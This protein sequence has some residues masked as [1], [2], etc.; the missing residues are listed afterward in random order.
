[1][2]VE[3]STGLSLLPMSN[4]SNNADWNEAMLLN[5]HL[6]AARRL[7]S[8]SRHI[9][10]SIKTIGAIV[11]IIGGALSS[12]AF[13]QTSEQATSVHINANKAMAKNQVKT[14]TKVLITADA[15]QITATFEDNATARDF[16]SLLPLTLS[17]KD[18]NNTE[19]VSDLPRRLTTEGAPEGFDPQV[20]DIT[21]YAPWGNLAIFYRDFGYAR[22]LVKLG[23]IDSVIEHLQRHDSVEVT[24]QR[25]E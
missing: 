13:A 1:M 5:E 10:V 19:K 9:K 4:I 17:L 20:G 15:K 7:E 21:I 11:F 14:M 8:N 22:G 6:I 24:I 23:R 2:T 12:I 3:M 25:A 16:L 18:Y